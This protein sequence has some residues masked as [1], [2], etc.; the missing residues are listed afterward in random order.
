MKFPKNEPPYSDEGNWSG[1]GWWKKAGWKRI[2][3][4]KWIRERLRDLAKE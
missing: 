1:F 2:L 4:K 3:R